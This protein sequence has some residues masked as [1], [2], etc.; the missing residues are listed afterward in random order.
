MVIIL[1][2]IQLVMYTLPDPTNFALFYSTN[3]YDL[4]SNAIPKQTEEQDQGNT[5]KVQV[6][7]EKESDMQV[8]SP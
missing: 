2:C 1:N 4:M 6:R 3:I 5:K 8:S 7:R